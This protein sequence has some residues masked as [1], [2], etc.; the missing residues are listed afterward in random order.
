[1]LVPIL[2]CQHLKGPIHEAITPTKSP[3]WE[4]KP[5]W[6]LRN[7]SDLPQVLSFFIDFQNKGMKRQE[8]EAKKKLK[9]VQEKVLPFLYF[10]WIFYFLA[11]FPLVFPF[12]G[13]S[14][15]WAWEAIEE[16]KMFP[17]SWVSIG[18]GLGGVEE[19]MIFPSLKVSIRDENGLDRTGSWVTPIWYDFLIKFYY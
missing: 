13:V 3:I 4:K 5:H 18:W 7:L 14:I 11:I 15:G 1:M 8:K 19:Q 12:S 2:S 10:S 17:S 6:N 9:S 16:R